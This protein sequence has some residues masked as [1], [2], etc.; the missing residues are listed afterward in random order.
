M[1]PA[2]FGITTRALTC[3]ADLVLPYLE[4]GYITAEA[5]DQ[6]VGC[7]RYYPDIQDQIGNIRFTVTGKRAPQG[8]LNTQ[9]I[10]PLV[11]MPNKRTVDFLIS[12]RQMKFKWVSEA[13]PTNWRLR[14][15]RLGDEAGRS[16]K[17]SGR[18][19]FERVWPWL[20][21]ALEHGGGTHGKEDL[22]KTIET[23]SAQ[24][25]PLRNG[26]IVTTI[27]THPSGLKD[28]NAWLAGG[29]LNEIIEVIPL[30]G[31]L[32]AKRGLQ[33]RDTDRAQGVAQ[34]A[35]QLQAHRNHHGEGPFT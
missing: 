9:V 35:A 29:N 24:L 13:T 2:P 17:V 28:A 10:G 23:C 20:A 31:N 21:A 4:T 26:A 12:C 1:C 32:A 15:R 27:Q 7:R 11:M 25:H 8:Q 14:R 5:G 3:R 16:T 6:W 18:E 30:L 33:A 34:G 19:E 22:W